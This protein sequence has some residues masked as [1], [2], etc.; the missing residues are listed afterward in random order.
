MLPLIHGAEISA[1]EIETEIARWSAERFARLCNAVAWASPGLKGWRQTIPVFTERVHVADNG[2]DAEWEHV[3]TAAEAPTALDPL[4][5][6]GLNVFQYKKRGAGPGNRADIVARLVA[7]VRGAV[8]DVERRTGKKLASYVL[9]TNV[10]LSVDQHERLRAAI[11]DEHP[12]DA[13]VTIHSNVIGA[14]GLAAMI[15]DLPHLRSAFFVTDA[16]QDWGLSFEAHQRESLA[17]DS[18]EELAPFTGRD[19]SIDELRAVIDSPSVRAVVVTGPHMIG[20]SRLILEATR[21]RD[22]DVVEALDS[23]GVN[24]DSMRRL[25][26]AGRETILL[27]QDATGDLAERVCRQALAIGETIKIIVALPTRDGAP[28]PNFG[29]DDRACLLPVPP[30]DDAAARQLFNHAIGQDRVD[31][32]IES[33]I[34]EQAGGLPGIL[35]ATSRFGR[36]LRPGAGTFTEQIGRAFEAKLGRAVPDVAARQAVALAALLTYVR[37]EPSDNPEPHALCRPAFGVQPYQLHAAIEPLEAAGYLARKGS[38]VAVTPPILANRLAARITQGQPVDVLAVFQAL[39]DGGRRRLLRRLAQLPDR[40]TTRFWSQLFGPDGL[41]GSLRAVL[42]NVELFRATAAAGSAQAVDIVHKGLEGSPPSWRRKLTGEPRRALV[43]SLRELMAATTTAEAAFRSLALLAEAETEDYSN[44]ATGIFCDAADPLNWQIPLALG[45]R[46]RVQQEMLV[47][48]RDAKAAMIALEAA[49]NALG[50]GRPMILI[51]SRGAQ[52]A[53]GLPVGM[54]LG[55]VRAYYA[56]LIDVIAKA[57]AD[58]RLRVR[59]KAKSVWPGAAE[60]LVYDL[61]GNAGRGIAAFEQ[62]VDHIVR[63][64]PEFSVAQTIE[65]LILCR[66]NL[67]GAL[68]GWGTTDLVSALNGLLT[69]LSTASFNVRLRWR[70]GDSWR[71]IHREGDAEPAEDRDPLRAKTVAISALAAEACQT[72]ELLSPALIAWCD[73]DEPR[74]AEQ[75]WHELG[76]CD[77]AGHWVATVV[78]LARGETS[79]TAAVNYVGGASTRDAG[80]CRAVF[81]RMVNA[82]ETRPEAIAYSSARAEGGDQASRRV[83]ELARAGTLAAQDAARFAERLA[84][85]DEISPGAFTA[86]LEA[87]V[88]DHLE[89]PEL[90]VHAL[91]SWFHSHSANDLTDPVVILAWRCLEAR[92]PTSYGRSGAD[93]ANIAADLVRLDPERGFRLAETA[94]TRLVAAM[95]N[96]GLDTYNIWS[97]FEP[98]GTRR[99]CWEALRALDRDRALRIVLDHAAQAGP[100]GLHLSLQLKHLIR[101]PD[102]ADFLR[103]YAAQG[104]AEADTVSGAIASSDPGYWDIACE[105]VERYPENEQLRR[106]LGLSAG[107]FAAGSF[108]GLAEHAEAAGAEIE[109]VLNRLGGEFPHARLWLG[110]L[111]VTYRQSAAEMT[112]KEADRDIDR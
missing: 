45:S 72:P 98:V 42:N 31:F 69:R 36:E 78:D 17:I 88:G 63:E 107:G 83:A 65:T 46:L 41:L 71:E 103:T 8:V 56:G 21:H 16:F 59:R 104:L 86:L 52:P 43:F 68:A 76:R 92:L 112:R 109:S 67:G 108:G 2:I 80:A 81:T 73:T 102:D 4:L 110:E 20:K 10:D 32:G 50:P 105:I 91:W 37:I 60:R 61:E 1:D 44:N 66:S 27:L 57:A 82:A 85:Q 97:P 33:W 47:P 22:I 101:L 96:P 55:D 15:N 35:L 93:A 49:R 34:I 87:I 40:V 28:L 48:E 12:V 18:S 90:A 13:T 99:P 11:L 26:K 77:H 75:F 6:P 95:R 74:A 79:W 106:K 111:L 58:P 94:A 53:G 30:L 25:T 38:F 84:F 89:R 9:W 39:A 64:D 7:E 100:D 19:R 23:G 14:A 29:L 54:T 3:L 51:P 70:L 24:A 5:Q 62:I